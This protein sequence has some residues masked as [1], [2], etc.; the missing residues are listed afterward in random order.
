MKRKSLYG[1][2]ESAQCSQPVKLPENVRTLA[3]QI[4]A[5]I[6]LP[7]EFKIP[8]IIQFGHD[9]PAVGSEAEFKDEIVIMKD[10]CTEAPFLAAVISLGDQLVNFHQQAKE[11]GNPL[12]SLFHTAIERTRDFLWGIAGLYS[13]KDPSVRVVGLRCVDG[14]LTLTGLHV[15]KE[16]LLEEATYQSI[17]GFLKAAAAEVGPPPSMPGKLMQQLIQAVP[18]DK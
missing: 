16:K 10:V 17:A 7:P 5:G 1:K 6:G 18:F 4:V 9:F 8:E 11:M 2:G 3:K 12:E 14:H 13:L 15:G